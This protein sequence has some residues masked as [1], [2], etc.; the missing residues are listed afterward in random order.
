M[1]IL[2]A[3]TLVTIKNQLQLQNYRIDSRLAGTLTKTASYSVSESP[4]G[5]LAFLSARDFLAV[6]QLG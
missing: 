2:T 3:L 4:H 6:F 1:R 5:G